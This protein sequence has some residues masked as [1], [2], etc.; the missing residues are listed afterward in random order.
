MMMK[1]IFR[2]EV[3][4]G[5]FLIFMD[6]GI[7]YTK[8]QP[9]EMEE[10]HWQQHRELIHQIF[11]IL[12]KHDLYMKLE[13]CAFKQEELEYLGVIIGKGK[14]HM[15]P[16][17]LMAMANYTM[18]QNTM[19]VQAFLG[20]TGYYWYFIQ[21]YLQVTWPLLDLTKKTTPWHWGPDQ[22]KAFI[23]LKWLMCSAP[24]LMQPDFNKKFYLQTDT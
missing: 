22:E 7:I 14:T 1:T 23:T 4:E 16:K 9:G 19:D 20:F 15:D 10:W 5:W 12:E 18:P 17:K 24:V 11:D 3:Q 21:G 2:C 6:N 8:W 13:K